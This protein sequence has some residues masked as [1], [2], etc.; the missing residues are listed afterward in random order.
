MFVLCKLIVGTVIY[1]LRSRATIEAEIDDAA[2]QS[3]GDFDLR[4]LTG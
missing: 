3:R 2:C 4:R 1:V